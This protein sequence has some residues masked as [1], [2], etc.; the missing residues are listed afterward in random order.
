M[1][2][3]DNSIAGRVA[4]IH[5]LLPTSRPA[6]RRR[7]FPADPLPADGACKGA[8]LATIK[9][10][11]QPRPG[12]RPVPQH[13]AQARP[14]GGDR[15]D[16]AGSARM[17]RDMR[18]SD[19]GG[20]RLARSPPRS[21]GSTSSAQD[22]EDETHNTTRFVVL[23]R[24]PQWADA[25]GDA[26]MRHHLRLPRP[27]HAGGA[28][29]GD[30]RLR[31]QRHQH[32]QA[33]ELHGRRLVLRHAVLC[34]CRGPSRRAAAQAGARGAAPSSRP[35]CGSSASTRRIAARWERAA[36]RQNEPDARRAS[37]RHRRS[38]RRG[39]VL[40]AHRDRRPRRLRARCG[41]IRR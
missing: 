40:R 21:T 38:R 20:H 33:G 17:V 27:Q 9:T 29:Q 6:H 23:A 22:I 16:T 25:L 7:V 10:G 15:G 28:L 24:E 5:H 35:R 11:A 37:T 32:D 13:A 4:D 41:A 14:E 34:R 3:I 12:A 18:R 26:S 2:P 31:H 39:C 36:R 1:I 8:T 19:Q 30:G